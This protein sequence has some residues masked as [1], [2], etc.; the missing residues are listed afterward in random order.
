M[1]RALPGE[2][3]RKLPSLQGARHRQQEGF[4]PQYGS[5]PLQVPNHG[6]ATHAQEAAGIEADETTVQK[7]V[8]ATTGLPAFQVEQTTA[9]SLTPDGLVLS[10]LWERKRQQIERTPGL[11]VYRD[12]ETFEDVGGC[13]NVKD[14]LYRIT[15]GGNAPQA[16]VRIDEID[17]MLAGDGDLSGVSQDQLGTL[18]SY[19]EDNRCRGLLFV[20]P[21][22]CSK[23]LISKAAG[24]EAGVPTIELDLGACKGSLVGQSE[25]Q[26]REALKVVSSVSGNRSLWIATAN[27]IDNLNTALLRR[28]PKTFFFDLPSEEEK[29]KVWEIHRR[30]CGID[31]A[32]Q[33]PNDE[34]WAGADIRNCC[35]DARD[36]GCELTTAAQWVVPV[37]VRSRGE[38]EALRQQANG[39]FLS[40]SHA[41]V[42]TLDD[43]PSGRRISLDD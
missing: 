27:R 31:A 12:G 3:C 5:R 41:G 2:L 11:S 36:L 39:R 35:E 17:K 43:S 25:R 19:M 15:S 40:A 4:S 14:F 38:I 33:R 6:A 7:A 13:H 37:G 10:D 18:L 16:I 9:M 1:I 23:S 34:H 26:L 21:P 28:F 29:A 30:R 42:F 32:M 20:G 8:A 24:N 22:G